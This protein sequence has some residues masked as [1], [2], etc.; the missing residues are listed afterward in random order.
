[1]TKA[2]EFAANHPVLVS[3]FFLL[4]ALFFL[5]ESRRGGRSISP[6]QATDLL[7]REQGVVIDL[8]S[9]DDFRKGHI[10]GSINVPQANLN[11]RLNEIEKWKDRPLIFLCGQGNQA[12]GAVSP[13][14]GKGFTK[15]YR[16]RG[17][18]QGWRGE[19]L[20]VVRA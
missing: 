20:P 9:A 18:M 3:A 8:R 14:R 5:N 13:L 16:I 17:G 11:E 1:M 4:W 12:G 19:N 15:L 7:N 2:L 6:Q 10:A